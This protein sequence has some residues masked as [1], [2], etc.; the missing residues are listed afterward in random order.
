MKKLFTLILALVMVL[1]LAACGGDNN[2]VAGENTN[3]TNNTTETTNATTEGTQATTENTTPSNTEPP[4][5]TPP[6][7]TPP[8][9]T[10]VSVDLTI[11]NW[12]DYFE[13]TP[14]ILIEENS[15]GEFQYVKRFGDGIGLKNEYAGR[16]TASSAI[17][18]EVEYGPLTVYRVEYNIE[19]KEL[20]IS[21]QSDIEYTDKT[22]WFFGGGRDAPEGGKEDFNLSLDET[23]KFGNFSS[24]NEGR[25]E[26]L[27]KNGKLDGN[28]YSFYAPLATEY[29]I[30]RIQGTILVSE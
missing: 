10:P 22:M 2:T 23:V 21:D 13:F 17:A 9:T 5:T 4:A 14:N 6:A 8:A 25:Y 16:V 11:E 15:F 28:I 24:P 12:G 26:T 27:G 18:V 30:T 3:P 29:K 7:T 19:T 20:T 1:S